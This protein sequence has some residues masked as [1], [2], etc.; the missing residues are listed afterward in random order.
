MLPREATVSFYVPQADAAVISARQ[1]TPPVRGEGRG[2]DSSTLPRQSLNRIPRVQVPKA[3]VEPVP[4]DDPN[5]GPRGKRD[6]ADRIAKTCK[7]PDRASAFDVPQAARHISEP[8]RRNRPSRETATL[9]TSELWPAREHHSF[10][11]RKSMHR[12]VPRS[13]LTAAKR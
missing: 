11:A 5:W 3:Y 1:D 4:S 8:V 6:G 10:P 12:T 2:C 13:P 7:A 9:V